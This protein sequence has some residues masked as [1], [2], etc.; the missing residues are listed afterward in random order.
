[1]C[2]YEKASGARMHS[3]FIR[4]GGLSKDIPRSLLEDIFLF[5][6]QFGSRVDEL[7]CLL[8]E[9]R[10]WQSRLTS[11]GIVSKETALA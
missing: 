4:P 3:A 5:T 11:V 9:N 7:E 1:M 10:I 6:E 2:F 8:S